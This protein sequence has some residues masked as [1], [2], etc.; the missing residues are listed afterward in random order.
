MLTLVA[1]AKINLFLHIIGKR[2]DG[3][4]LLESVFAFTE[5]G[6][7]LSVEPSS[8]GFVF[9]VTGPFAQALGGGE[10]DERNCSGDNDNL[11]VKAAKLFAGAVGKSLDV[12]LTLEKNLPV[13]SGI[14]GGSADAAATLKALNEY[15]QLNWDTARLEA[16]GVQLGADVPA[17][18]HIMPIIVEGIGE[19]IT[20]GV[21]YTGPRYILLVNPM[22]GV[23]TPAVFREFAKHGH[24]DPKTKTDDWMVLDTGALQQT[25]NS[26]QAS[27]Q[28]LCP[29][30]D[31][32]LRTLEEAK[33]TVIVRMA[34]SGATC[35]A[36]FAEQAARDHAGECIQKAYPDWWVH[37]DIIR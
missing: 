5:K 17:C 25:Q 22:K 34:G 11:V 9:T 8:D 30:I 13:A 15:W 28:T 37:A 4:H 32:V 19:I 18:L 6:D 29:D 27:A 26:L 24:F 1:P 10:D 12:K 33:D 14:G 16:L 3:Y 7:R 31:D 35:F 2:P 21:E 20:T 23:S 36:L